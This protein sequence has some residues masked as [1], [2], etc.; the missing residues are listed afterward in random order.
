MTTTPP[1]TAVQ[2]RVDE[3]A[4]RYWG[5]EYWPPLANLARLVEEVG[6]VA[7]ALNQ[8]HGA[9]RVKQDEAGAEVGGELADALFAL[10]CIANSTGVD[11]QQ[12]FDAALD[13]YR[14]RDEEPLDR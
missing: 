4:A 14:A 1:L 10:V 8:S 9:K 2:Q 5:G 12:A 11:L 3:W 6:E 7:R 13:K